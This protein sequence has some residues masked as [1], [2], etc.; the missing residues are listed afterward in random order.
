MLFLRQIFFVTEREKSAVSLFGPERF[1]RAFFF[2]LILAS[3]RDEFY[4]RPSKVAD[5]WG[6]NN[7]ILSGESS[8]VMGGHRVAGSASP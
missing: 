2:R 3:N 7:E 4:H 8:L 1:S 5:F 6:N